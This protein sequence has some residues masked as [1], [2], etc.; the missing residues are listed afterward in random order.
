VSALR[1]E[2]L[3]TSQPERSDEAYPRVRSLGLRRSARL[4]VVASL[5]AELSQPIVLLTDRTDRALTLADELAL[6]APEAQRLFFPEPN[7]LFYEDA[8]WGETTRRDRLIVLSTFAAY[9][10]PG[11]PQP[12]SARWSSLHCGL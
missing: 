5:A 1:A 3:S 10:I 9:H 7:P 12:L 8:A 6:L 11:A 4:P 2:L